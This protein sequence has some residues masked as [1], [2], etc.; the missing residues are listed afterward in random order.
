MTNKI[1]FWYVYGEREI[2]ALFSRASACER[3]APAQLNVT[4]KLFLTM[5]AH[6]VIRFVC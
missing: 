3:S 4:S 5:R 6:A 2:R 1:S